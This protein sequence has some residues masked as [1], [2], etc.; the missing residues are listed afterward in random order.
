MK[1]LENVFPEQQHY[2]QLFYVAENL[3]L[4]KALKRGR[5]KAKEVAENDRCCVQLRKK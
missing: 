3:K 4:E 2:Q 5:E 1:I